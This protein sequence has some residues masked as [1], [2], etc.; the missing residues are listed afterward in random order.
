M[1][2]EPFLCVPGSH[3]KERSTC[4]CKE[5]SLISLRIKWFLILRRSECAVG[6]PH[7]LYWGCMVVGHRSEKTGLI[8]SETRSHSQ[9]RH[10]E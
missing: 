1:T 7:C 4:A 10:V 8:F 5:L 6:E 2:S 9:V 3:N